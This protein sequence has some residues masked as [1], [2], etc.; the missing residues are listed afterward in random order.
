MLCYYLTC[1]KGFTIAFS[2]I[3]AINRFLRRKFSKDT[4]DV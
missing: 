3:K 2:D 1:F 4:S